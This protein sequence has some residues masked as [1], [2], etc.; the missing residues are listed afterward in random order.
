VQKLLDR[1]AGANLLAL[2]EVAALLLDQPA[3]E[4]DGALPLLAGREWAE[5]ARRKRGMLREYTWRRTAQATL[6]SATGDLGTRAL[7]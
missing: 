2:A 1:F 5:L 3:V 4:G 6:P 7:E